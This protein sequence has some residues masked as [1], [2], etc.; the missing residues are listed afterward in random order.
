MI[1]NKVFTPPN[2]KKTAKRQKGFIPLETIGQR[3]K[4]ALMSLTW[5]TLPEL[6]LAAAI[7]AFTLSGLLLVFVN[8][9]LLN[10]AN[11]NSTIAIDHAQFVLEEIRDTDFSNISSGINNGNWTWDAAAISAKCIT[12]LNDACFALVNESITTVL[13]D[14]NDPLDIQVTVNWNDRGNKGRSTV[15]RTQITNI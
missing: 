13:L 8:C 12:T 15:L 3:K 6:L 14:Q 10:S 1:K 5:F 4:S 11:R 2:R 7:L 9:I